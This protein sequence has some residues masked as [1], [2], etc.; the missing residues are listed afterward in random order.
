MVGEQ[1]SATIEAGVDTA[2]IRLS[3]D[4]NRF[5][6]DGL[7]AS[8]RSACATRAPRV[9]LDF[10]EVDYLNSTGIALIVG[11]LGEARS[12]GVTLVAWGLSD[13]FRE[14]FEITR[15]VE[16]MT[17]YDDETTARESG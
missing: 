6:A 10:T 5:A 17:L 14:I 1:F 8:F 13:H 15:I 7:D 3:G 11:I 2:I 9:A 4:I 12:I 16:F